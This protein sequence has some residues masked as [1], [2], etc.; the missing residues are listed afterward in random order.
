MFKTVK[1]LLKLVIKYLIK[2]N[3]QT[4][5]IRFLKNL[6]RFV[7]LIYIYILKTFFFNFIQII[8]HR[9]PENFH[10]NRI[11]WRKDVV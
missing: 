7:Y 11:D 6:R 8:L 10:C 5:Y 4:H 1:V 9:R 2:T 3:S